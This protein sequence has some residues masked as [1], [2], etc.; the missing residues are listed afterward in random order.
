[1]RILHKF[2]N[3]TLN[4]NNELFIQWIIHCHW[5]K[6]KSNL[7]FNSISNGVNHSIQALLCPSGSTSL[8]HVGVFRF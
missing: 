8:R 2:L 3:N 4:T 5:I 7:L 1:M 6:H